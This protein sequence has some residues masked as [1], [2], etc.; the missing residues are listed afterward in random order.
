MANLNLHRPTLPPVLLTYRGRESGER[1]RE[2]YDVLPKLVKEIMKPYDCFYVTN[3]SA[4]SQLKQIQESF[5]TPRTTTSFLREV[6]IDIQ[7]DNDADVLE[8]LLAI[9]LNPDIPGRG[10]HYY[11]ACHYCIDKPRFAKALGYCRG[12]FQ[13]KGLED[14]RV[15]VTPEKRAAKVVRVLIVDIFCCLLFGD[16]TIYSN[17]FSENFFTDTV[18]SMF[19]MHQSSRIRVMSVLITDGDGI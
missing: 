15:T 5:E 4:E 11:N 13:Y 19:S 14:D 6:C 17:I 8:K 3:R 12:D 16:E 1:H 10:P 2:F 18:Q 7:N 9:G